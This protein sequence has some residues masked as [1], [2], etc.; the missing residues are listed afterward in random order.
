MYFLFLIFS[1]SNFIIVKVY[2]I[3]FYCTFNDFTLIH[4]ILYLY[5]SASYF[6]FKLLLFMICIFDQDIYILF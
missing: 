3:Y 1:E 6:N 4:I 2:L 5:I